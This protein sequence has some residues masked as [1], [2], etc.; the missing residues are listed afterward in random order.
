MLRILIANDTGQTTNPG[1]QSV[2]RALDLLMEAAGAVR[3]GSLPVGFGAESFRQVAAD[4][5]A[6][7]VRQD[8]HFPVGAET[9][10]PVDFEKW[11]SIRD[12]LLS[13][14]P[15][16]RR[17]IEQ[18]DLLLVNGEGSIHHNF[19]RALAL[20]ALIDV[21][22]EL[23]KPAA[24]INST[25]Q[26]MDQV[27]LSTALRKLRSCHLREPRSLQAIAD[28]YPKAF[29]AADLATLAIDRLAAPPPRPSS[30]SPKRCLVSAGVLVRPE[31]L[32][33]ILAT[34]KE[35]AY[36]PTYFSI[37]DGGETKVST[38]ACAELG[39]RHVEASECALENLPALLAEQDIAVCGRHHLILFL[40]KAGVPFVPLPSNT[41]K[42]EATLSY[43]SYP[44]CPILD[45]HD[46]A[47]A[48]AGVWKE[49]QT[50]S[51][52][53]RAGFARAVAS[54]GGFMEKILC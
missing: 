29:C 31:T 3:A 32:R 17:Q 19:P 42:I 37:G 15:D 2:R 12:R 51:D 36:T 9:A 21:A 22:S 10:P 54:L 18:A 41:W 45:M 14:D 49:R 11:K 7:V 38:E 23:G 40:M 28:I 1:C 44:L 43:L 26:A 46:L 53:G 20:L 34:V 4:S 6:S 48:I 5:R 35:M 25:I 13:S 8:G 50:L 16:L 39:V 30:R 52:A 24:L 47:D 27:L 33:G